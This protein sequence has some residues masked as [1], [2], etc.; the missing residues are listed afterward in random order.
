MIGA[1]A[2]LSFLEADGARA[3][4]AWLSAHSACFLAAGRPVIVSEGGAGSWLPT[5]EGVLT[6]NDLDGAVDQLERVGGDLPRY[7][8]AARE[9]AEEVLHYRVV[10]PW[11]LER[12]L[13]RRLAAVA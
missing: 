13:P 6:F 7:S 9:A 1:G 12:A 11:L 4:G 2:A 8:R 10:L 3:Q 5:G